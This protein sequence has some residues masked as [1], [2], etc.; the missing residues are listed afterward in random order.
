MDFD[1]SLLNLFIFMFLSIASFKISSIINEEELSVLYMRVWNGEKGL[2]FF[3]ER[4]I[5]RYRER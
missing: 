1:I 2:C 5:Q 3:M 4:E